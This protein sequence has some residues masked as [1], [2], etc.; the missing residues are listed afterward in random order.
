[1]GKEI[2]E[3]FKTFKT[4]VKGKGAGTMGSNRMEQEDDEL[5][6]KVFEKTPRSSSTTAVTYSEAKKHMNVTSGQNCFTV[7]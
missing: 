5:I 4:K 2:Y 6:R 7:G 1:M 3:R